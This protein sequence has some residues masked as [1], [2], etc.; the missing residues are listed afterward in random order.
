MER[1]R[2]SSSISLGGVLARVAAIATQDRGQRF[3]DR[4]RAIFRATR[5]GADTD[6]TGDLCVIVLARH[7]QADPYQNNEVLQKGITRPRVARP[8][9]EPPTLVPAVAWPRSTRAAWS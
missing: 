7:V 3:A 9:R 1:Q 8:Q 6:G 4:A 2:V 5:R